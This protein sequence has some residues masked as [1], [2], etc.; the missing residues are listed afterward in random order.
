[1][2]VVFCRRRRNRAGRGA[3]AAGAEPRGYLQACD[4]LDALVARAP[5]DAVVE[6]ALPR[7]RCAASAGS[8]R[9][10]ARRAIDAREDYPGEDSFVPRSTSSSRTTRAHLDAARSFDELD[11]N[12]DGI[13]DESE[14]AAASSGATA[15]RRAPRCCESGRGASRR[16]EAPRAVDRVA[17]ATQPAS[18]RVAG[19]CGGCQRR[20]P[21]TGDVLSGARVVACAS[22]CP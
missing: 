21:V 16:R 9:S 5:P 10:R 20:G 2:V 18:S 6:P 11:L 12:R 3:R 7:W 17:Y 15:A 8:R 14:V 22:A 13:I 19:H 4:R 1:M